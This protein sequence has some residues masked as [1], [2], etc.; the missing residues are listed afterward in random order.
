MSKRDYYEVLGISKSA[1]A[2]DIKKAYLRLA[3][4]YHPDKNK[5]DIKAENSFKEINEAYEILKDSQKRAAYD[6]FGHNS[7]NFGGGSGAASGFTQN[8]NFESIFDNIDSIFSN[9]MGGRSTR[10]GRGRGATQQRGADLQYKLN[11]TLEEAFNGEK[12]ELNFSTEVKCIECNGLGS[13]DKESNI[14]NQCQGSG[15]MYLQQGF[16]TFQQTCS[17]CSGS[18][19]RIK[20][21]CSLCNGQ[22]RYKKDKNLII[23]IP[24]GIENETRMRLAG[25][26]KAGIR[27]GQNGDLYV[28]IKILPHSIFSL[29][30]NDLHFKLPIS[31]TKSVLGGEIEIPTIDNKKVSLTIPSGTESGDIIRLRNKGMPKSGLS[32]SRGDVYAHAFVCTIKNLTKKQKALLEELDKDITSSNE[33]S[34][35]SKMKNLWRSK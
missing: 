31:L 25:E 5:G 4:Q 30:G 12:K 1:S 9:M 13:K 7:V 19:V 2:S 23:T 6:Q 17:Y 15:V 8:A 34:V 16:V 11:I 18:G 24:P 32:S 27:G 14:C 26:G 22:G 28:F 20:N 10:S 35:F 29:E 21:P 33:S 3:K